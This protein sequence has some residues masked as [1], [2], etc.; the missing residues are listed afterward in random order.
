[1]NGT[2]RGS[3]SFFF[4]WP[5][6][7]QFLDPPSLFYCF[8]IHEDFWCAIGNWNLGDSFDVYRNFR[9]PQEVSLRSPKH[10]HTANLGAIWGTKSPLLGVPVVEVPFYPQMTPKLA[11]WKCFEPRRDT[12]WRRLKFIYTSNDA[13]RS[14]FPIAHQKNFVFVG[15]KLRGNPKVEPK[16]VP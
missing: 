7:A 11:V 5:L 8:H 6:L 2:V 15:N 1:M 4:K 12:S 3:G 9:R 14:Q 16:V 13:P 10:F